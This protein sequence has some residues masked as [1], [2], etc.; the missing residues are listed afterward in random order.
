MG[1]VVRCERTLQI[2][3]CGMWVKERDE[4]YTH[5]SH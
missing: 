4:L 2:G 5:L 1:S 3:G